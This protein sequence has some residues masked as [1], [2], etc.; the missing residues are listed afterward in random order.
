MSKRRPNRS[1]L[2]VYRH[3]WQPWARAAAGYREETLPQTLARLKRAG[4]V[5]RREY[6][7]LKRPTKRLRRKGRPE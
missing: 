7:R 1:A 4:T 3:L 2:D 5:G 6:L